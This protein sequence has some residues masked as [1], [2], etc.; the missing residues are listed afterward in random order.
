MGVE[1]M[2]S[3]CHCTTEIIVLYIDRGSDKLKMDGYSLKMFSDF[4]E[5][6]YTGV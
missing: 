2:W 6:N 3:G 5:N 4:D 1:M